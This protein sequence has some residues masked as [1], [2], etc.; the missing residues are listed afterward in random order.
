MRIA[1]CETGRD[2]ECTIPRKPSSRAV[3]RVQ[4]ETGSSIT[5]KYPSVV[6]VGDDSVGEFF[7][8]ALTNNKQ[9]ADTGTKM[10]HVGKRTRSKIVSKGISAGGSRNAYRGLVQ[11]RERLSYIVMMLRLRLLR[12]LQS[13]LCTPAFCASQALLA[14]ELSA[15]PVR[16]RLVGLLLL[17]ALCVCRLCLCVSTQEFLKRSRGWQLCRCSQVRRARATSA[18]VTRCSL[19]TMP[20]PTHIPTSRCA[21]NL[22]TT[23]VPLGASHSC[24][25]CTVYPFAAGVVP[26]P[27]YQPARAE[28]HTGLC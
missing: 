18:S 9:Q 7:S 23:H 21:H 5:W 28:R 24:C 20:Q 22:Y 12:L 27:L 6:L 19:A 16:E 1:R 8:V 13:C 4:V 26:I 25:C 3:R 11:V 17:V 2:R 15:P 14:H 10:V